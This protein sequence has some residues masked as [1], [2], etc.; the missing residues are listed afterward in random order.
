[1]EKVS[2][3]FKRLA[4]SVLP[5]PEE[6]DRFIAAVCSG[7]NG[8]PALLWLG[9]PGDS[10]FESLAPVSWQ[11]FFVQRVR[12][13]EK[14]G[15]H[16]M[17]ERGQY[18]CMDLASVF[19]SVPFMTLAPNVPAFVVDLCASPGG[20]SACAWRS[21]KP[22]MLIANE[23]VG[24]RTAALISNIRRCGIRPCVVTNSDPEKIAEEFRMAADLVIVDAPCAGQALLSRGRHSDSCFHPVTIN[25]NAMR[26]R[27]IIANAAAVVSPGGYL[28]YMTCSYSKEENEGILE[29][30][31]NQRADFSPVKIESL[32]GLESNIAHFPCY[33]LWPQQ[34]HGAG[35]FTSLLRR[36]G[37]GGRNGCTD[38]ERIRAVWRS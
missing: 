18:Y 28:S 12:G 35:G 23:V 30:F 8:S 16:P 14:A 19:M 3:N 34:G 13:D 29:W 6:Q 22:D 15:S 2:R 36:S 27:R 38:W 4:A 37:E 32:K 9:D 17:H 25:R 7:E 26:Q 11:P 31:L 10:P 1:M 20:K 5:S 24:K 21:L 33:R